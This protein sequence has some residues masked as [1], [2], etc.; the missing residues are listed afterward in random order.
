M[1]SLF[2]KRDTKCQLRIIG[3]IVTNYAELVLGNTT[4]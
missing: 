3:L 4:L 2:A 1:Y